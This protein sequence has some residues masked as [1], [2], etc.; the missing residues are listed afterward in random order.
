[1]E[2]NRKLNNEEQKRIDAIQEI[3]DQAQKK[4]ESRGCIV[5]TTSGDT[6]SCAVVGRTGNLVSAFKSS[7]DGSEPLKSVVTVAMLFDMFKSSTEDKKTEEQSGL[8][9][10][11]K[12]LVHYT[13]NIGGLGSSPSR[14][15]VNP[16]KKEWYV[17]QKKEKLSRRGVSCSN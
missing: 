3:V 8:T 15:T 12:W 7:M 16:K 6:S 14:V 1:M 13:F 2:E 5:I 11:H 17:E 10:Q 4:P 9:L